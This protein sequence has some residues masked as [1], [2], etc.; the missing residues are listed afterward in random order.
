MR[1]VRREVHT[2][3]QA[4]LGA[5]PGSRGCFQVGLVGGGGGLA[6]LPTLGAEDLQLPKDVVAPVESNG[7]K[8]M[9]PEVLDVANIVEWQHFNSSFQ[10]CFAWTA[11]H[12]RAR[13]S[14][15]EIQP[16]PSVKRMEVGSHL[17]GRVEEAVGGPA[18]TRPEAPGA[19]FPGRAS[20]GMR[21]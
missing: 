7:V 13:T 5:L 10:S 18:T 1:G 12:Q 9:A 20:A 15:P 19:R 14:S 16:V 2:A 21:G 3:Q 4:N 17:R 11:L 8:V 6:V